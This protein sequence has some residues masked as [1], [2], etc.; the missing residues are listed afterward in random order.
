MVLE[1]K[2]PP[3]NADVRDVVRS[4]AQEDSLQESAATHSLENPIDRGAW[5]VS[6]R[7]VAKSRI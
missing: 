5:W 4:L 3:A 1:V 6:V 2:N 7:G